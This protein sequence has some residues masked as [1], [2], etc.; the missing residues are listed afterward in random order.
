MWKSQAMYLKQ[1][2]TFNE[3]LVSAFVTAGQIKFVLLHQTRNEDGI[4]NFFNEVHELYIKLLMN[5]F[6]S[7]DSKIISPVFDKRVHEFARRFLGSS[8]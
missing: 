8:H 1:V 3:Q 6:Y 2:D 4:K 7:Y 5:P